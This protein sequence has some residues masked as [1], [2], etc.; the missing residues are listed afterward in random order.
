MDAITAAGRGTGHRRGPAFALCAV[1]AAAFMAICTKSSFLYPMNDWVDIHC[2]HSVGR[3]MLD[4]KVLYRDIYEQKGPL[5]YFLY[6]LL[7]AATP[8][9][10]L[11]VYVM[12][13]VCFAAFLYFSG[14]C[15]ALYIEKK[16]LIVALIPVLAAAVASA[17]AFAHGGSV[18][19]MCLFMVVWSMYLTLRAVREKRAIPGRD[20][21]LIG[22]FASAA[23][24]IKYTLCGFYA[25]LALF[26][27]LYY[28]FCLRSWRQ[29]VGL[30]GRFLLGFVPVTAVVLGYFVANGAL[31]ELFQAY[32]YDNI[33]LYSSSGGILK[34][35][36]NMFW[37]HQA[38]LWGNQYMAL[39][40]LGLLWFF[41]DVKKRPWEALAAGLSLA[42]LVILVSIGRVYYQY[43]DLYLAAF[44]VFGLIAAGGCFKNCRSICR[45]RC[46]ALCVP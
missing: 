43:Y 19:E 26:V 30:V 10:F 13:S 34:T 6:A 14:R 23:L 33:F 39:V 7:A 44:S 40:A 42:G 11:S 16:W 41:K 36:D 21:F 3:A 28:L 8:R 37:D 5:L 46:G 18:E 45:E 9:S 17:S 22:L 20:G 29:L 12:E 15:A 38:M 25:G 27:A 1:T 2:F 32:F 35:A 4:G 31:K 24:W